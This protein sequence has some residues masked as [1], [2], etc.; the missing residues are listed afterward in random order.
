MAKIKGLNKVLKKL[1]KFGDEAK[2]LIEDELLETAT[3]IRTQARFSAPVNKIVGMGGDLRQSIVVEKETDLSY[4]IVVGVKYAPY[5]EFG[6]G[7]KVN[8]E[9]LVKSGMP[10]DYAMQFKGKGIKQVNINP[11]PYLFPAFIN[12]KIHFISN[13]KKGLKYL[14]N[15]YNG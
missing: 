2:V 11:Q 14:T 10:K 15:K 1:E 12:G 4:K 8:L 13:L 3:E 7:T 9:Y 5:V 6:T